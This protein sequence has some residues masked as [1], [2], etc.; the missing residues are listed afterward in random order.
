MMC[1]TWTVHIGGL[2]HVVDHAYPTYHHVEMYT[3]H[4]DRT[5]DA[6]DT[7]V[8]VPTCATSRAL[9]NA[10]LDGYLTGLPQV[11]VC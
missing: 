2:E 10:T 6:I 1:L 4:T 5:T 7:T 8:S 3:D 9:V 11:F